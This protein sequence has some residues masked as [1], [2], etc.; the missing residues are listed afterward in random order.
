MIKNRLYIFFPLSFLNERCLFTDYSLA[1]FISSFCF[2]FY[3]AVLH[4]L[5]LI[6]HTPSPSF[7][8]IS[9]Q[10]KPLHSLNLNDLNCVLFLCAYMFLKTSIVPAYQK[11]GWIKK[12]CQRN[13]KFIFSKPSNHR[14]LPFDCLRCTCAFKRAPKDL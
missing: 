4:S 12:M 6:S 2:S 13:F 14:T 7:V 8:P 10:F 5:N 9:T 3:I 1:V 11:G